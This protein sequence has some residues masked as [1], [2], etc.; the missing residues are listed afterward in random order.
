MKKLL[1]IFFCCFLSLMT[2]S[3][4]ATENLFINVSTE[5]TSLVLGVANDS[6]VYI[7]HYG[8][9]VGCVEQFAGY[10]TGR[11]VDYST[12]DLAY[13]TRGGRYYN[14]P[15][16]AVCYADGDCNTELT[17]VSHQVNQTA[18]LVTT[19]IQLKDKKTSLEVTLIYDAYQKEDIIQAR[20]L[21]KNGGKKR[22]YLDAY[23]SS[24]ITLPAGKH[25]LTHFHG[26]WGREMQVAREVL[27][28]GVKTIQ[29]RMGIRTTHTEN[30]SFL[31]SLNTDMWSETQGEVVAG[32]LA[33]SGNYKLDFQ[34]DE[35]GKL[36]IISGINPEAARY[37]LDKGDVFETPNMIWT[38]SGEGA[39]RASRNLHDWA[40]NYQ[41]YSK[42]SVV[43]TLLNSWE[44]AYFDF[45]TQTLIDM[46]DDAAD[47]GLGMFVLDDGWFGT[48]EFARNDA[49]HG[50][51]DWELNVEKL[52][53]GIDYIAKH[54]HKRGIKFGIWI[55]PEMVNKKSRLA[56]TH[57]HWIVQSKDRELTTTRGQWVLDLTNPE[58]QDFVFGVFDRTMQLSENIDY[59]KWDCNRHVESFGSTYLKDQERFYVDYIQGLYKVMRRIRAKY[60]DVIIQSCSSG[61]GRVDYG[62]LA[63]FDE[64]WTSDNTEALSR[65]FIQYGTNLIYP[66][67]VTGSHVSAAPSHQTN[68]ITP[69]K[70]R[71]DIAAA[72]RLGMELQPKHLTEE[73]KVFARKAI[74]SYEEYRD[75]VFTGD[76][77]RLCSPHDGNHY[78]LMYVSKDKTRAVVMAYCIRFQARTLK[79]LF[80]LQG[81]DP[82]KKYS[83]KELNTDEPSFWGDGKVFDGK[84]L[85][86]HGIN[87]FLLKLYSSAIFM[88]E[89]SK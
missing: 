59:I 28:P 56:Q 14:Q 9:P 85:I 39:G 6:K 1:H 18:S 55:E 46:I 69:L 70:F 42:A 49:R 87:P 81:L 11:R 7:H 17:Y 3:A 37:P 83:I 27:T 78:A 2:L 16:L 82:N 29:N 86:N 50:L 24:V 57:P 26:S 35:T 63:Y 34:I 60:P 62:A 65:V 31:L 66:A 5:N 74:A 48:G 77:Y 19:E 40:R 80:R 44:G 52:P 30:P 58:V 68:N 36:T 73:E 89:E 71:F 23:A 75:L 54:A 72:G 79:P 53:E 51:G 20:T 47:M 38:W 43:P 76:L 4:T 21:I 22:V 33:W 84:Y 64:V 15:A 8:A 88:I 10:Q 13:P 45:T 12:D 67:C 61:G 32:A 41:C 25:L